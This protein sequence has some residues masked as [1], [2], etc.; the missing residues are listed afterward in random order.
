[1]SKLTLKE[2]IN[3]YYEKHPYHSTY[4]GWVIRTCLVENKYL[5]HKIYYTC[6]VRVGVE[7]CTVT[8]IKLVQEWIDEKIKQG[9]IQKE[10]I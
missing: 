5:G 8:H 2:K 9:K 1:M 6:D 7:S 3:R 4:K 10:D